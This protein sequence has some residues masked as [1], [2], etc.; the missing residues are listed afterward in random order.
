MQ[1]FEGTLRIYSII[2]SKTSVIVIVTALYSSDPTQIERDNNIIVVH[3]CIFSG[4]KHVFIESNAILYLNVCY[5]FLTSIID[6][7]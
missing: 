2:D 3:R 5:L 4:R 1:R 6:E 7:F